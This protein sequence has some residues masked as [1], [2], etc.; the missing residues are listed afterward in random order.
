M[1]FFNLEDMPDY[2]LDRLLAALDEEIAMANERKRLVV[3]E[4]LRRDAP[5][6][7]WHNDA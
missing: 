7:V 5:N 4:K 3:I 2:V 1:F 6:Q